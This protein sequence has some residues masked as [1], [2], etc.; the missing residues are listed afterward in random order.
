MIAGILADD[1]V[2][3]KEAFGLLYWLEDRTQIAAQFQ[4][5]YDTTKTMLEDENLDSL[6]A[7]EL[8]DLLRAA[9]QDLNGRLV[10]DGAKQ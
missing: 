6:E 7:D 3:Y 9:H 1:E 10:D 8:K 4:T 2:N 5:L